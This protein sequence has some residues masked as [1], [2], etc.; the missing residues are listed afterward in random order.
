ME[1]GRDRGLPEAAADLRSEPSTGPLELDLERLQDLGHVLPRPCL[2]LEL[3]GAEGQVH[4]NDG[5]ARSAGPT[6]TSRATERVYCGWATTMIRI[7]V[8]SSIA[9][10][11]PSRPSPES[12]TPP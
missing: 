7:S 11:R 2:E 1:V 10:R 12:L 6:A 3:G 8:M 9:Q 5:D 4:P